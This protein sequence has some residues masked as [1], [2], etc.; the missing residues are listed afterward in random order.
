MHY[1]LSARISQSLRSQKHCLLPRENSHNQPQQAKAVLAQKS[2]KRTVKCRRKAGYFRVK[3][4]RVQFL[5]MPA[6][7][8][9][10][11]SN[12]LTL[13]CKC[14][15]CD[16]SLFRVD[17]YRVGNCKSQG[18]LRLLSARPSSLTLDD[19]PMFE[20]KKSCFFYSTA[21]YSHS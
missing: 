8:L 6:F 20:I 2:S 4:G 21:N 10:L 7:S 16:R 12:Y 3:T 14:L 5:Q 13:Y 9:I 11:Y 19:R 15:C 17:G 18:I 1:F